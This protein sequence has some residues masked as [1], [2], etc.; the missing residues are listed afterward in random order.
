MRQARLDPHGLTFFVAL[1]AVLANLV[2]F[3]GAGIDDLE[4]GEHEHH[5][6]IVHEQGVRG[7]PVQ[8]LVHAHRKVGDEIHHPVAGPREFIDHWRALVGRHRRQIEQ[9]GQVAPQGCI[10]FHKTVQVHDVIERFPGNHVVER[11]QPL[12]QLAQDENDLILG[13]RDH[14]KAQLVVDIRRDVVAFGQQL[15]DEAV[16]L[17]ATPLELH[18]GAAR[19]LHFLDGAQDFVLDRAKNLVSTH[20]QASDDLAARQVLQ[21]VHHLEHHA[22]VGAPLAIL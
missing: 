22:G 20:R 21:H 8:Q 5:R 17:L 14:T 19:A 7:R 16:R 3:G 13:M 1:V 15:G 10:A 11:H 4:L 6:A 12:H 2:G 18:D 9:L